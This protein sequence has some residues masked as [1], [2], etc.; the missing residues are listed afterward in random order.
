MSFNCIVGSKGCIYP[1][2][3]SLVQGKMT[4]SAKSK[5][6]KKLVKKPIV[7]AKPTK[8][9]LAQ[10]AKSNVAKAKALVAKS[11][12]AAKKKIS[13]APVKKVVG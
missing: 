1:N 11:V 2:K 9:A 10:K 5:L 8:E 6:T 3:K 7:A 12:A 13:K 4:T